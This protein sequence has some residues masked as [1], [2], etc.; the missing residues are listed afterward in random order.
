MPPDSPEVP[1]ARR[2]AMMNDAGGARKTTSAVTLAVILALRGY[3]VLFLD[4]DPQCD[5]TISLGYGV[6]DRTDSERTAA[7]QRHLDELPNIHDALLRKASLTELIRPARRRIGPGDGDESFENI[8]GLSLI[9]GSARM[10]QAD[11]ELSSDETGFF[12][13]AEA[14]DDLP[15][16]MFH[17][18]MGDCRAARGSLEV[19]IMV[20]M[21][22]IIGC[23]KTEAKDLR[24]LDDL[25]TTL[26]RT[27][28]KFKRYGG[29]A[30]LAGVLLS[31]TVQHVSQGK[32]YLD[33]AER[34]RAVW[35][36]LLLPVV[37]RS[38]LPVEA[39]DAQEPLPFWDPDS[40]PVTQ[41]GAV[42]DRLG[43]SDQR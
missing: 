15:P 29:A 3:K 35:G 8:P 13:L 43:F 34:A 20:G 26:E 12:W 1:R 27:Q 31:G 36:D 25:A 10:D 37:N 39:Y 33:M 24:G 21:E 38:V 4:F 30:K 42:A 11:R 28:R 2:I 41:Y 16:G 23:S 6:P 22:E 14:L 5:G 32:V 17:V 40:T 7:V 19:S 18:I 9:L